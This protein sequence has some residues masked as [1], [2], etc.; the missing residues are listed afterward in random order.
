[1][2]QL[3][4]HDDDREINIEVGSNGENSPIP[5]KLYQSLY[6]QITGRTEKIKKSY[7]NNLLMKFE[8]IEQ[9]HYKISQI[10]NVHDVIARNENI[11]IFYEK[12]TKDTFTSFERFKRY[13][14]NQTSA[15]VNV[16]L[17]YNFSIKI[18]ETQK[19]QE[20][21]VT[22]K[23]INRIAAIRKIREEAP[24]FLPGHIFNSLAENIAEINVEYV[25][26]VVARQFIE[27][28]SEWIKGVQSEPK[29]KTINTLK[30]YSFIIPKAI[31]IILSVIFGYFAVSSIP[32]QEI[33]NIN[34]ALKYI[35]IY[36]IGIYLI[37][38]ISST[39]GHI[40]ENSI[41]THQSISYIKL[42]KGDERLIEESNTG[43]AL[44]ITKFVI[45]CALTIML[46]VASA[47][48]EKIF[49]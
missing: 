20:Y 11:T 30:R 42:N 44:R 37:V 10:C 39:A 22:I 4:E 8:D 32:D 34:Q 17:K 49:L 33:I 24:P 23:L 45:G 25:D 15:T 12:D 6:H 2:S 28:F 48:L 9:L 46:G 36:G 3:I 21:T 7:S 31:P 13:N 40:I 5:M 29:T 18:P 27:A 1:M 14:S 26:Y 19:P 16:V 38:T 35:A 41:D 43:R 47:M